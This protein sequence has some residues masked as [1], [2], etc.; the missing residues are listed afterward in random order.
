VQFYVDGSLIST[1]AHAPFALNWNSYAVHNGSH[2]ISAK[3][4]DASGNFSAQ[5]ITITIN[6]PPPPITGDLNGDHRV[7]ILDLSTLLS[8]WNKS[9][10][11]DFNNN[12]R[13]DIF[14]LSTLLSH[15]G[16]DNSNYN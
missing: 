3:A 1:I 12:G 10:A 7:N 9:G 13:V 14:D 2:T 4:L 11:G 16:Q 5:S 8:H 6:N 15:Y